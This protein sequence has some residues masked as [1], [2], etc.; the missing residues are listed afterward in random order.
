MI[1][2]VPLS[3]LL[4]CPLGII[5]FEALYAAQAGRVS[6]IGK[7]TL[8]GI[9]W[10]VIGGMCVC[11]GWIVFILGHSLCGLLNLP[12]YVLLGVT[13]VRLAVS[14]PG[15]ITVAAV[16]RGIPDTISAICNRIRPYLK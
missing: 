7:H 6:S 13:H 5:L 15:I 3:A 2:I 9:W 12:V 14:Q 1:I 16:L 8:C 11:G 10:L 4:M